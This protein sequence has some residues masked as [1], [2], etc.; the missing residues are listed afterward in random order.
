MNDSNRHIESYAH[1]GGIGVLVEL[2]ISDPAARR[3]ESFIRLAK[4]IATHIAAMAPASIE[5]LLGQ[6]SVAETGI[7]VEAL[8][9]QAAAELQVGIKVVRFMRW[10]V[11]PQDSLLP[12]PPRS[13][14]VIQD[15]RAAG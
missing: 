15:L 12:E 10:A 1:D 8:L 14:A 11:G 4:D 2:E 3:S 7:T 6:P 5:D 9:A 13:P